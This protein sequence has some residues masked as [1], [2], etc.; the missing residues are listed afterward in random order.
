MPSVIL[1]Q[2]VG[3]ARPAKS[4]GALFRAI[5]LPPTDGAGKDKP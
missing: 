3:I 4:S 2:A 1:L 5:V